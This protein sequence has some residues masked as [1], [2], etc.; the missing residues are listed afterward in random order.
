MSYIALQNFKAGLDARRSELSSVPGALL[1]AQDGHISQ[2]GEFEKRKGFWYFSAV[3]AETFGAE[4]IATGIAVFG[5][6][7]DPGGWATGVYYQQLKHPAVYLGATYDSAEHD[8]TAV[9]ASTSYGGYAWVVA[10]YTDGKTYAYWNGIPIPAF[11]AGTVLSAW[12]ANENLAEMLSDFIAAL[13][14]FTSTWTTGNGSFDVY[15]TPGLQ[16]SLVIGDPTGAVTT[17]GF[18]QSVTSGTGVLKVT[19]K[20]DQITPIAGVSAVGGFYLL[21]GSSG[22]VTHIYVNSVDII[23]AAVPFNSNLQ[24]TI[25][26]VA[27]AVNSYLSSPDYTA[28]ADTSTGQITITAVDAGI[29]KN[30]FVVEVVVTGNLIVDN[31]AFLLPSSSGASCSSVLLNPSSTELLRAADIPVV[32]SGTNYNAWAT[33]IAASIALNGIT[34]GNTGYTAWAT[35]QTVRISKLDRKSNDALPTN[36]NVVTSAGTATDATVS[37]TVVTP[38]NVQLAVP[39]NQ[40]MGT[41]A[42]ASQLESLNISG[43]ITPYTYQWVIQS[44][45]LQTGANGTCTLASPTKA[46]TT[47]QGFHRHIGETVVIFCKV[48][49]SSPTPITT[50]SSFITINTASVQ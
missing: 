49:D 26:D 17:N 15:S 42:V 45:I 22:S 28:S 27:S 7:T 32:C 37:I 16:Y 40:N 29:A 21:G 12:T 41:F 46:S 23:G 36:Y 34:A 8:M 6:G 9:V 10:T 30:G 18:E 14:N 33:A 38:L 2:G 43:G 31:S 5:S 11:Y 19:Q 48:T 44:D 25:Q 4:T 3:A 20:F 1:T 50:D 13:S 47:V 39:S 35:G 24:Q